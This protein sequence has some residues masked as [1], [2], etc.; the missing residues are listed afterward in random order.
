MKSVYTVIILVLSLLAFASCTDNEETPSA[1]SEI[2]TEEAAEIVGTSLASSSAGLDEVTVEVA[3]TSEEMATETNFDPCGVQRD[4]AYS[5]SSPSG[6]AISYSG[7]LSYDFGVG[8]V[9]D[10][11]QTFSYEVAYSSIFDAPRMASSNT[12]SSSLSLE[13]L[14]NDYIIF[15]VNGS[16]TRTGSFDSKIFNKTSSNASVTFNLNDLVV[17][18]N[19]KRING[20]SA[21]FT[22]AGSTARGNTFNMTGDVSFDGQGNAL[23]SID[24]QRFTLDLATGDMVEV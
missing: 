2:T 3:E 14:S 8:C 17:D 13:S 7:D 6:A 9:G 19:D 11:P 10:V 22:L 23:I 15:E 21:T 24:G 18:L 20:G 1:N 12:G 5:I 4:T 16:Y